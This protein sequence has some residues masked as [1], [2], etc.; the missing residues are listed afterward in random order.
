M[1]VAVKNHLHYNLVLIL[2][3]FQNNQEALNNNYASGSTAI[4]VLLLDGKFLVA[5]VGD[6]KALLC[7][8]EGTF[9]CPLLVPF[10]SFLIIVLNAPETSKD[11]HLFSF[12]GVKND[13]VL[14]FP[15]I[16]F[17]VLLIV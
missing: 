2:F 16:R 15:G 13:M 1:F 10:L 3:F 14:Q 11:A 4:V 7:S 5:S 6:S 17:L 9:S 8:D 12:L